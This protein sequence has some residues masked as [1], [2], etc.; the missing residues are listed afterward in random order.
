MLRDSIKQ[1]LVDIKCLWD[2][3]VIFDDVEGDVDAIICLG[4]YDIRVAER[5]ADLMLDGMS[6][7]AIITGGFG[8][9]THD[10][11]DRPEA[12]IFAD[13]IAQ[14]GI[15]RRKLI[16]ERHATNIGENIKLSREALLPHQVQRVAFVTKPQTQRRLSGTVGAKWPEIEAKITA[17]LLDMFEQA[18]DEQGMINLVDEMVG[19]IQRIIEYPKQGFQIEMS[20]PNPVLDAYVRLRGLGFD[21]HCL[22]D[23]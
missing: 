12:E 1:W 7:I 8:N 11:F 21:R 23:R 14:R 20:V 4:S 6:Q 3:H 16:I 17:P 18:Q 19:D 9:W 10:T 22:P 5:C 2:Y 13:V 15:P